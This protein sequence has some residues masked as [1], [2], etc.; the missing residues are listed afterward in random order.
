LPPKILK[1]PQIGAFFTRGRDSTVGI[2][3]ASGQRERVVILGA[4][5]RDFHN[6]NTVFRDNPRYDV[7]AFTATQIPHIDDRCYPAGLCGKLYPKGIPIVPEDQLER[8]IVDHKVKLAVFSYSDVSH[9]TV[10]NLASR[11][12]AVGA[13]F[14]LLSPKETML[15]STK[16]V[17]AVCAVR[18][19]SGKSQTTRA[20]VEIVNSLKLKCVAARH[21]MPYGDLLKQAVQRFGSFDDLDAHNCTIEEREE[22]EPHLERGTTVYA[23]IDYGA[24]LKQAQREADVILWDGGNNDTP[25]F[26]PDLHIC[27]ADPHRAGHESSYHPGET[28]FRMADVI[29]INK[30]DT[31][32]SL[33]VKAVETAAKR[34][35]PKAKVIKA[36]SPITLEGNF[37]L[38]GKSVL[39]VED[40]PTLTHGEM[41]YGA[42]VIAAKTGG[43]KEIIDPRPFVTGEIKETFQK[44]PN[45]GPL[46][47]AMGYGKQQLRDLE[48]TIAKVPCDAVLIATP[49]NL[50]RLIKMKQPAV[51]VR[52]DL[53]SGAKA[54]LAK[55]IRKMLSAR[56]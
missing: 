2:S 15:R 48:R 34:L 12:L 17:I 31:V 24:I 47:P 44:Y 42:G 9:T 21:P 37:S 7:V 10:M 40:G 25:F 41:Q 16:P 52:Y 46:L 55:E 39:V 28:N 23:G 53:G 36:T 35:N 19:G 18:T 56:R 1:V 5:G 22:Y 54:A 30:V 49:I 45:I 51:R 26:T 4:A 6:F 27:V 38:E 32:D 8:V 14:E 11:C 50:T 33:H 13:R 3:K 20:C 29:L 43:A